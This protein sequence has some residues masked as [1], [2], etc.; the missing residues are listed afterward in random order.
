MRLGWRCM[1]VPLCLFDKSNRWP[2]TVM[3]LCRRGGSAVILLKKKKKWRAR[4]R[5]VEEEE[6]EE[7]KRVTWQTLSPGFWSLSHTHT[8]TQTHTYSDTHT[9]CFHSASPRPA[10]LLPLGPLVLPIFFIV[11]PSL[12]DTRPVSVLHIWSEE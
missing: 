4:I 1:V 2:L 12:I 9:H 7:E 3:S 10:A 8:H 6:Q 11:D 5:G